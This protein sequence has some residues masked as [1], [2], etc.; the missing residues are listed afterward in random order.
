MYTTHN[1]ATT[2]HK[3]NLPKMN[4]QIIIA[5]YCNIL[6]AFQ[7]YLG[8]GIPQLLFVKNSQGDKNEGEK[9][10]KSILTFSYL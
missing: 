3:F 9:M 2:G 5:I 7:S 10:L 8:K 4:V 6:L 1:S